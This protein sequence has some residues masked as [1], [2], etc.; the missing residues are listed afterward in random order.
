MNHDGKG[1][2][3]GSAAA[4]RLGANVPRDFRVPWL[5]VLALATQVEQEA[6]ASGSPPTETTL[7][8]ARTILLFHR[9]M[10]GCGEHRSG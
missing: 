8:L 1:T 10:L 9:Q 5:H 2:A 3:R 4:A 6:A 7:R